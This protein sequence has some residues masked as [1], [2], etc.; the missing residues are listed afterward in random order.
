MRSTNVSGIEKGYISTEKTVWCGG[1]NEWRQDS[2]NTN[3]QMARIANEIGWRKTKEF[4]WLCPDCV[5]RYKREKEQMK[6]VRF[7]KLASFDPGGVEN[8]NEADAPN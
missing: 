4:G 6:V 1:C 5:R 3:A 2:A 8:D 7:E